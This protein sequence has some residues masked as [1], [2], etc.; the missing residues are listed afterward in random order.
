[1]MM[2]RDPIDLWR[3]VTTFPAVD[4]NRQAKDYLKSTSWLHTYAP[5]ILPFVAFAISLLFFA[6]HVHDQHR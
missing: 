6:F 4:V 5:F 1:M 3:R 2:M